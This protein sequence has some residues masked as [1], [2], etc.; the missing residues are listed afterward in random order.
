MYSTYVIHSISTDGIYIGQCN[1]LTDRLI[2]HNSNRNKSTAGKGPW[3]LIFHREFTTR[4]EAVRLERK[5]K[6]F[7]NKKYLL[8]WIAK[9]SAEHP[10]LPASGES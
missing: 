7:K 1:D 4:R 3:E 2:R 5:L 9:Q 8:E 6:S 10:E